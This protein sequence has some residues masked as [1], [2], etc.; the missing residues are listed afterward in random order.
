VVDSVAVN[1]QFSGVED[2]LYCSLG[3]VVRASA[4]YQTVRH[5]RE[6]GHRAGA[7][8]GPAL[9]VPSLDRDVV[10]FSFC[11]AGEGVG[12]RVCDDPFGI[13]LGAIE[14]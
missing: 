11:E 4:G 8:G 12:C 13:C 10:S 6:R 5:R 1:C 3:E 2:S 14:G 7:A 9:R